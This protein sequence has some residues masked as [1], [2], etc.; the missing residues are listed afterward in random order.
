MQK[1]LIIEDSEADQFYN[2]SV[3]KAIY[4][5]IEIY[6][7][8]DGKEAIELLE[9]GVEPD[10][11]LLD[12]NMPRMNG[13][14]FLENYYQDSGKEIPVV[15]MLTSSDQQK[16]EEKTSRFNCVKDYFIKPLSP[17]KA[18]HLKNITKI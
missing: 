13:H 2:E 7:A 11:I 10:V 16:D 6:K 14:E 12:I 15:V 3:L 1:I 18:L 5:E 8:Y 4:E 9:Q 17:E